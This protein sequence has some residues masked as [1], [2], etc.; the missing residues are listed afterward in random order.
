LQVRV[1]I[2]TGTGKGFCSG[3]H[4]KQVT[5]A[6]AEQ[7]GATNGSRVYDTLQG[8]FLLAIRS[9]LNCRK[10][11]IGAINGGAAGA[12]AS[13]AL[14]CDLRIMSDS[15]FLLM[16]FINISLVPDAGASFFLTRLANYA[17][18]LEMSLDGKPISATQCLQWG[19]TNRITSADKLMPDAL[20]WAK[21]ISSKSPSALMLSK[22]CL[23]F[24]LQNNFANSYRNESR[25]QAL[26]ADSSDFVEG[27]SAFFGKRPAAFSNTAVP[28]PRGMTSKL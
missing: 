21:T 5:P 8:E 20:A 22:Q 1:V 7:E 26:M 11:V 4:L 16:A 17:R 15:A 12:G 9:V 13:L 10:I 3:A 6:S 25:L 24:A 27:V 18:A 23:Q 19:L 2:L 28:V 14:A